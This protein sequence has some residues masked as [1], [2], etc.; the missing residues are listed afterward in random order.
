MIAARWRRSAVPLLGLF[1][2]AACAEGRE[3]DPTPAQD[4]LRQDIAPEVGPIPAAEPAGPTAGDWAK[5][6]SRARRG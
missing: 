4:P 3:P 5:P 6:R 2:L 1:A